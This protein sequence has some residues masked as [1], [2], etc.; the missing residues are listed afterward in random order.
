[1]EAAA[2]AEG[3][4]ERGRESMKIEK[5]ETK[6][7]LINSSSEQTRTTRSSQAETMQELDP[8][9]TVSA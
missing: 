6:L 5:S 4:M 7:S 1:M 2:E 9:S 3:E 8:I